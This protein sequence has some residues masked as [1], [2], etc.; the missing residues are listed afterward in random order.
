M[1]GSSRARKPKAHTYGDYCGWSDERRWELIEGLAFAMTAPSR[2]HSLVSQALERVFMAFFDGKPCEFHHAP[3][4]IRLPEGDEPDEEVKTVVQPDLLVVCDP[5]KLDDKGCRGAPDLVVEILSPTTASHDCVRKK[6]IYEK[7]GVREFWTVDPQNR[8]V[9]L[10]SLGSDGVFSRVDTFDDTDTVRSRAFP[11]LEV[12]LS[13]VF[14]TQPKV[15]R[16][17]PAEY[18]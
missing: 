4:D 3:F 9:M 11:G 6:A 8:V 7:H 17:G 12:D 2:I 13:K 15:V 10:F 14:P 18:G 1:A 5:G 16:E